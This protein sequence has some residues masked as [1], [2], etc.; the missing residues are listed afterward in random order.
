MFLK[1]DARVAGIAAAATTVSLLLSVSTTFPLIS[2]GAFIAF[3]TMAVMD[4]NRL[5]RLKRKIAKEEAAKNSLPKEESAPL[6][7]P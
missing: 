6:K 3:G 7:R 1:F 4:A 2:G 5:R